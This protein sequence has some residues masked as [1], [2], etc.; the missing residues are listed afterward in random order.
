MPGKGSKS[1]KEYSLTRSLVPHT[2]GETAGTS[3]SAPH[4]DLILDDHK[5]VDDDNQITQL[6][7]T[8]RRNIQADLVQLYAS[9]NE[10]LVQLICKN[11]IFENHLKILHFIQKILVF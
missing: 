5:Q 7:Q 6:A 10:D 2:H 1:V 9:K 8:G 3:H 4:E 11:S